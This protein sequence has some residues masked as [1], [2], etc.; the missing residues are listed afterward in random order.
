[1]LDSGQQ[2]PPRIKVISGAAVAGQLWQKRQ[3]CI[4]KRRVREP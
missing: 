2:L 3:L 1:M 4:A